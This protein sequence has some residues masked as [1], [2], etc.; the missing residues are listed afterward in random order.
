MSVTG[1]ASTNSSNQIGNT[2]PYAQVKQDFQNL[3]K[4]LQSGNLSDAQQ[5]F[6][7]LQQDIP[8]SSQSQGSQG[9]NS[10][11][12]EMQDLGSALQSGDLSGAQKAFA[13]MQKTGKGH[14]HHHHQSSQ[15]PDTS[16]TDAN[17]AIKIQEM[18]YSGQGTIGTP[19]TANSSDSTGANASVSLIS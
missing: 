15:Q 2:N 12:Q 5:A 18:T 3:G 6:A 7:T 4:A 11:N 14:G 19:S 9:S 17:L 10:S 8:G 1:I 16:G 13:Q